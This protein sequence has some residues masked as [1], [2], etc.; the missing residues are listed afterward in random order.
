MLAAMLDGDVKNGRELYLSDDQV[1]YIYL[2]SWVSPL[3]PCCI[4]VD[5]K[6][7]VV[8]TFRVQDIQS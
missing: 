8:C 1:R 2:I 5:T 7:I 6:P 4:F 3:L